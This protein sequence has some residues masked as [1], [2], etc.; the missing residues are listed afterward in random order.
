MEL[1]RKQKN[2]INKFGFYG[3]FKNLRFFDPVLLIYL[4][5]YGLTT[6]HI[7]V[8]YAI[9]EI[10]IW[11]F[12]VPSGVIADQYGKKT[13]LMVCFLFYIASFLVFALGGSFIWFILAMVLFGLGEAFRSGTHKSI[14]MA[15]LDQ[16]DMSDQKSKTYGKTRSFS[17][18]GSMFSSLFTIVLVIFLPDL[19]FLFFLAV[20]P[21]V[22][23]LL[24]IASYPN[25]LNGKKATT[26][27][28]KS[29]YQEGRNTIGYAFKDSKMRSILISSSS[30]QAA[31]KI[32]KDFVQLILL[33]IPITI[34]L[35]PQISAADHVEIYSAMM[36][37]F[38]FFLSALT[39]RF[40]YLLLKFS[41]HERLTKLMWLTSG[42]ASL[43]I[44]FFI[45]NIF[46]VFLGFILLYVFLNLRKPLMVEIIGDHA[47]KERRASILSI[48]SQLTSIFIIVFAPLLGYLT[49]QTSLAVT[50]I[51]IGFMMISIYILTLIFNNK[52]G[53]EQ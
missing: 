33:S 43:L 11:I 19:K 32:L 52:K 50:F 53:N 9:R 30:Y 16:E 20:I 36:Y 31:F 23:D 4:S 22:I 8:L 44:G 13:E 46:I 18:Y 5:S 41:N 48:D 7:G 39:S 2:Q 15:Y 38:I 37:A 12:E 28:L 26:F 24:L 10:I 40:S 3:F 1:T 27:N 35:F 14:I 42:L 21:Y 25:S 34:L 49:D 45:S 29:F 6:F 47:D 17:M 51:T